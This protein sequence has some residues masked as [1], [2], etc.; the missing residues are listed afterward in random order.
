MVSRS[1]PKQVSLDFLSQTPVKNW[2]DCY[3]PLEGNAILGLTTSFKRGFFG[4][5]VSFGIST[6]SVGPFWD[7][8]L[9]FVDLTKVGNRI[10]L[11]MGAE[12]EGEAGALSQGICGLS[13]T[14]ADLPP[15]PLSP[16]SAY[17][18]ILTDKYV[19][20]EGVWR[21]GFSHVSKDRFVEYLRY[22]YEATKTP[23]QRF[24]FF[25]DLDRAENKFPAVT[26]S[27]IM[28]FLGYLASASTDEIC[29]RV[30]AWAK[31]FARRDNWHG[32]EYLDWSALRRCLDSR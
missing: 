29:A 3:I 9:Q 19:P 27:I 16:S 12:T 6:E 7:K 26:Q 32:G 15:K 23:R 25:L 4:H 5:G 11:Q 30:E 1:E 20:G 24:E 21:P 10:T 31:R 13:E 28:A 14:I 2:R 8:Y 17:V 22:F 18:R